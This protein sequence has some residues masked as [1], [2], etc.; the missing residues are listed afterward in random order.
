MKYPAAKQL[1]AAVND[2]SL[3][4][5]IFDD[6]TGIVDM[7]TDLPPHVRQALIRLCGAARHDNRIVLEYLGTLS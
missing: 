6:D 7:P 5:I 1:A 3:A 4:R 2:S